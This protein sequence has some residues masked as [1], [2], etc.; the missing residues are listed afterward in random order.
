MRF[1]L[2][3]FTLVILTY[4]VIIAQNN[5][6]P[7]FKYDEKSIK[8]TSSG[9]KYVIV[10]EGNGPIAKAGDMITAHYH[11]L[12]ADGT[13]FDSSFERGTPFNT[14]IGV[15][16]VI[17]GWDEAFTTLKAG[18]KAVLI[19]PPDLGYGEREMGKI[20]PKSTL[21]FH[22][23][24]LSVGPP[25]AYDP[26]AVKTTQSGL[27]YVIIEE[28]TG[29]VAKAGDQIT[30]HYH[31]L[32]ADG[33]MF[34]SSFVRGQPFNTRIGVG[35][36]IRGWDEAFT[37]L[38]EGTKAVLIIP[39]NLGYGNRDMGSIPPNSTLYFHVQLLKVSQ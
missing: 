34:D 28:G 26:K 8:T 32:L 12:L 31:G 1:Y 16:R 13:L 33:K 24:L 19:I 22:V 4:H 38:K 35:Q 15:G 37:T 3:V 23:Q 27:Q 6:K 2:S 21:Y 7:P 36:V 30:A 5:D 25:Y 29:P 39:P 10:E 9:L 11:G 17:K 20:P 18:T 14:Q